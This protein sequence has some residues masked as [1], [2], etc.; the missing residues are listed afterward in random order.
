MDG[1]FVGGPRPAT[2][3]SQGTIGSISMGKR[4]SIASER[5]VQQGDGSHASGT[6]PSLPSPL[7]AHQPVGDPLSPSAQAS[8]PPL[9]H[10]LSVVAILL[11]PA[12]LLLAQLGPVHLFSPPIPLPSFDSVFNP[13]SRRTS[14][15]SNALSASD[16]ASI[17]SSRT[18]NSSFPSLG[19]NVSVTSA[20]S[21]ELHAP[22]TISVPAVSAAAIW[23]LF[24][25]FEWIGEAGREGSSLLQEVEEGDEEDKVFDFAALLQ[26]VA[27]VLAAD[28]GSR[29][30]ELVIGQVGSGSF[31]SPA[32]TPGAE[33]AQTLETREMEKDTA[34]REL[35]V[36]ADERAW[37]VVI[38]WVRAPCSC[39]RNEAD[40]GLLRSCITSLQT[41]HQVRRSKSASWRR[42][43]KRP[44]SRLP[45]RLSDQRT[46][47][48][49][50]DDRSRSGGLFPSTFS[51][52]SPPPPPPPSIPIL[53][54]PLSLR[55]PSPPPP[56]SPSLRNSTC[57]SVLVPPKL[58]L[59]R[60]S[61]A[62]YFQA[63]GRPS[64]K[65]IPR[66]G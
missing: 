35:L 63:R 27:D 30:V 56:P 52:P 43:L 60:G 16:Q 48:F 34:S 2:F 14:V 50:L 25:G 11:P 28:A 22:S 40:G 49:P 6:T 5:T 7:G 45:R 46:R 44:Q 24:R 57:R 19:G 29:G 65:T 61:S 53:P 47:P 1:V 20:Y 4:G 66:P 37:G 39:P 58:A 18:S 8:R 10:P 17:T 13:I 51:T 59:N 64:R 36:R 9:E 3:H 62:A 15:N 31:P 32:S 55:P 38:V 23:R 41:P 33:N 26:G 42:L 54:L 12:L 21:H